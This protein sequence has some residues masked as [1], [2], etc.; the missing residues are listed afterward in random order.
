MKIAISCE[1]TVD[2]PEEILTKFD[3]KTVPFS[4]LLGEEMILDGQDVSQK[5]FDYVAKTKVLPKTSAVNEVQYEEHFLK[6]LKDYDGKFEAIC[7]D[8][9]SDYKSHDIEECI[10]AGMGGF[11]I[12]KII[13]N[14]PI[15]ISNFILSPQHNEIDVKKFMISCGY[16][17]TY[18]II[19]KER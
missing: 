14:S 11:E 10:I 4:I 5:I 6:L 18:D 12:I 17:I 8:G 1:T 2:L 3:I 19:I 13:E 15:E 9:L 7:C 16:R